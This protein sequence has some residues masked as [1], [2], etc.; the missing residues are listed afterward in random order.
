[1]SKLPVSSHAQ[2]MAV[3]KTIGKQQTET[4]EYVG[5]PCIFGVGLPSA[6]AAVRNQMTNEIMEAI[7]SARD[8]E[9]NQ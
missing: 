8:E 5:K 4:Q 1:M 9:Q 6:I 7:D 2:L 3:L